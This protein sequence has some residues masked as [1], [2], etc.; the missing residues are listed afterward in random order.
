[1]LSVRIE[2]VWIYT[3]GVNQYTWCNTSMF[4]KFRKTHLAC[5]QG[6]FWENYPVSCKNKDNFAFKNTLFDQPKDTF[7]KI[8]TISLKIGEEHENFKPP[9]HKMLMGF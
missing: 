8:Q 6:Q 1:M 4:W 2:T 9:W 7:Q 3:G 5:F